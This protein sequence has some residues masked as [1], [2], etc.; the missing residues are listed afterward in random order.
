MQR[1]TF[2]LSLLA[3]LAAA[4]ADAATLTSFQNG[5][6]WC[7]M[8]TCAFTAQPTPADTAVVQHYVSLSGSGTPAPPSPLET[9]PI[10]LVTGGTLGIYSG[11]RLHFNGGTWAGGQLDACCNGGGTFANQGLLGVTANPLFAYR[12]RIDNNAT[13]RIENGAH[14]FW[15]QG[16][17]GGVFTNLTTGPSAAVLELVGTGRIGG[18]ITIYNEG[19]VRKSGAGTSVFDGTFH[20][21]GQSAIRPG[22]IE[23]LE[24]TLAHADT[25]GY[26]AN[27]FSEGTQFDVA[28]GAAFAIRDGGQFRLVPAS[29]PVGNQVYVTTGAGAGH[30]RLEAGG[31]MFGY[32]RNPDNSVPATLDFPP[33]VFEWTGG[34]MT[35]F[36]LRNIGEI[37]ITGSDAKLLAAELEN[38]GLLRL[39]TASLPLAG[40]LRVTPT[41]VF[42]MRDD[43]SLDGSGNPQFYVDGTLSK[44]AGPGTLTISNVA[45]RGT[46]RV[47]VNGGH[48][49]LAEGGPYHPQSFSGTIELIANAALDV[50]SG[51]WVW[52]DDAAT[53]TGIGSVN[54]GT[55]EQRGLLEPGAP[56]GAIAVNGYLLQNNY[57]P[58]TR[59]NVG[60]TQPVTQYAQVQ[61]TGD[62]RPQGMLFVNF[63]DGYAPDAGATFDLITVGGALVFGDVN[64]Y[65]VMIEGLQP[66]FQYSLTL[67]PQNTVRLTA[68]ND[69]VS[70]DHVFDDGFE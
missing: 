10:D 45:L 53:L 24:G 56:Y 19:I 67:S 16:N 25:P 13:L 14:L 69:G 68:L 38:A 6:I 7:S 51:Q 62:L 33:G 18:V 17:G 61:V 21:R 42:E 37:T 58:K 70:V 28:A 41:G 46:G 52:I 39:D 65:Q 2:V 3:G 23:V 26:E 35:D 40:I 54:A 63:R 1:T 12:A 30:V 66:G 15:N 4:P 64:S 55:F 5:E 8:T 31:T 43:S 11:G 32:F 59:I 34:T 48:L 29:G 44:D 60:G 27:F 47:E 50:P 36:T 20:N 9:G 57:T 49:H 22:T